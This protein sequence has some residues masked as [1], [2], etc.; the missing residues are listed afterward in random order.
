MNNSNGSE[1][2]SP[3]TLPEETE[4]SQVL[5]KAKPVL[6]PDVKELVLK[7]PVEGIFL[8]GIESSD[9]WVD[10][11]RRDQLLEADNFYVNYARRLEN[12]RSLGIKWVRFGPSY[13]KSHVGPEKFDFV[14]SDAVMAKCQTLDIEI[15]ADFLHFGLPEWLHKENPD[16][17]FFQN[18]DFPKHFISYVKSFVK[19]YPQ[20]KYFTLVNEPFITAFF[21]AKIGIWNEQRRSSWSDDKNF[22]RAIY[23]IA[24]A[25][26]C[27]REEIEKIWAEE[28]RAGVPIFIQ[29]ESFEVAMAEHQSR[30]SEA[31]RFNLIRFAALD[32]ILAKHDEKMRD[33]LRSQ[34][35]SEADYAW[36]MTHG[37]RKNVV[38]GIDHY[39]TCVHIYEE[40]SSINCDPSHPYQLYTL[41]TEYWNRYGV[42][43]IH[44]ETNA[45]PSHALEICQK[46]YEVIC[47]LRQEGYPLLG[48]GW[49][50]DEYQVGWHHALIGPRAYEETLVGLFYRG[51]LQPVGKLFGEFVAKGFPPLT[52]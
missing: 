49:Y 27:A 28:R 7:F 11:K 20:V 18:L 50:G 15:I 44:T 24:R 30:Q 4:V 33:F 41:I 1:P 17:P 52:L 46:T 23:N 39:P 35:F 21:S 29:N 38:L 6:D 14:L 40:T 25:V 5:E 37:S 8:T 13:S 32:L 22:V 51:E 9:P 26:I 10:G 43:L 3:P 45:W 42:P 12:I 36:C 47:Q 31:D 48:I 16:E 34:G 2:V 19:R